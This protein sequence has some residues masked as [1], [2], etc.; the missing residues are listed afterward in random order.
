MGSE[1]TRRIVFATAALAVAGAVQLLSVVRGDDSSWTLVALAGFSL[2][3]VL[4][5]VQLYHRRT[6]R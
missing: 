4:G 2:A 5:L 1:S 3:V 6:R